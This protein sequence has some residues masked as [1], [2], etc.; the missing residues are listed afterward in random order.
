MSERVQSE[1]NSLPE[2]AAKPSATPAA[3]HP[4]KP[5]AQPTAPQ[6]AFDGWGGIAP[7]SCAIAAPSSQAALAQALAGLPGHG[8]ARGLGR[9]YGDAAVD[10]GGTVVQQQYL[11]RI[12]GFD[13]E[14]GEVTCE[15]GVSLADLIQVFL[16]RGFFLPT[17][18]GTKFVTVGGAIAAD[19]HG[20]NHHA[21]GSFGV[22]V[23]E[24][25]LLLADGTVVNCSPLAEAEL[26][27]ATIGGM[28]LTGII[29]TACIR[30]IRVESGY[31]TTTIE[32]YE[33]IDAILARLLTDKV[34]AAQHRY[35]V[36][37]IDCLATGA[38]L[39]RT[40]LMLGDHAPV[41]ALPTAAQRAPFAPPIRRQKS[42]PFQAPGWALNRWTVRAFN[43][44]YWWSQRPGERVVDYD[45]WFYPLDAVAGWNRMYGRRGFVQYQVLFPDATAAAGLRA[46]LERISAAGA[47]SFLAVIKRSGPANPSPLSFLYEGVTLALDLPNTGQPLRAICH[48]LDRL[49]LAHG[50]RLYLA[51][52]ALMDATTFA[53]M[54]PRRDE[55]L[56]IK[57]R[58]DPHNR[59]QSS[60]AR[61]VGL[62]G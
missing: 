20:K 44:V 23:R 51:K 32:R 25:A 19:V 33:N 27:W 39:G 9:S 48:E 24:F 10:A 47:A 6:A 29:L 38:S 52:D 36:G 2:A 37:W 22:H 26:F 35:S 34:N 28:G 1:P 7:T 4:A 41:Q 46:V 55:F 13:A 56:A 16:P 42:I 62:L 50:G 60:L 3:T 11:N 45:R 53:A 12:L 58:V 18:P 5:S 17:T 49:T 43:Q 31:F 15:A 30:L 40:A 14:T 61:R 59:F 8:I 54:Y 21:D 57:R